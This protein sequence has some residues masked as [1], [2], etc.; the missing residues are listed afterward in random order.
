L[1]QSDAGSRQNGHPWFGKCQP[2]GEIYFRS[3]TNYTFLITYPID[4]SGKIPTITPAWFLFGR[5]LKSLDEIFGIGI[6]DFEIFRYF[7]VNT[8]GVNHRN[9]KIEVTLNTLESQRSICMFL[10]KVGVLPKAIQQPW[11]QLAISVYVIPE[12]RPGR[13]GN[14]P[15]Y[16]PAPENNLS[17]QPS[18]QR[19]EIAP[20]RRRSP[21]TKS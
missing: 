15:C 3:F 19:R 10:N 20:L 21:E 5:S 11:S 4:G 14:L 9:G 12:A 2:K 16:Q 17:I 1:G 6:D 8:H 13:S 7:A 18:T